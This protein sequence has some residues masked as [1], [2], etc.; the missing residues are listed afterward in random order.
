MGMTTIK[1]PTQLRDRINHE[2]QERGLSAAGLIESLLDEHERQRRMDAFG[3]AFRAADAEYWDEF[4]A[5]D[6]ETRALSD[7]D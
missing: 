7:D 3:R 5:W 2:A 1:V 4:A 6:F